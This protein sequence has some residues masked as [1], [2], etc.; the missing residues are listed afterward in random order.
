[1]AK[2][3]FDDKVQVRSSSL[4][5]VN[6]VS[7]ADLNEIKASNNALYATA[8]TG[9]EISF[10]S[11]KIYNTRASAATGALTEDLT[12]AVLG[13]EQKIYH[14]DASAPSLPAGWV[15]IGST[16]Y[17]NGQLNIFLAQWVGGSVVEYLVIKG[18]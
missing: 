7:A 13:V 17:T 1:M 9:N 18:V 12:G 8:V 14:N 3:T 15:A 10:D 4:P 11:K 2:I 5:A 16:T 6:V